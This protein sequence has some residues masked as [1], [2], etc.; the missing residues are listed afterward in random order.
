[1][2]KS[3]ICYIVGAGD[4]A[5]KIE[6]RKGDL[7]IAAD[8]GFDSLSALG[9]TPDICIGDFD[10]VKSDIRDIKERLTF[11]KEKDETDMY[12]AY[13]EGKERGYCEFALF[14]ALGGERISHTLANISILAKIKNNGDNA[15]IIHGK[16]ELHTVKN[17]EIALHGSKGSYFSVFALGLEAS[18]VSIRGAK[19]EVENTKLRYDFPIGVSNEFCEGDVTVSVSDGMLLIVKN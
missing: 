5:G 6:K 14:G 7:I 18:G 17:S 8:G 19:Y 10:S 1:M 16:T 3:R 2:N 12:L 13:L 9:I 15:V 11:P 4:F